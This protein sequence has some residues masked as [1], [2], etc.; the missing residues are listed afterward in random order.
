MVRVEPPV[1][2]VEQLALAGTVRAVDEDQD[3][4]IPALGQ[5]K[6]GVEQFFVQ[7]WFNRGKFFPGQ[8]VGKCGRFGHAC[9]PRVSGRRLSGQVCGSGQRPLQ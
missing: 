5:F 9:V 4:P 8:I 2:P 6:L 1:Q 7:L 3:G